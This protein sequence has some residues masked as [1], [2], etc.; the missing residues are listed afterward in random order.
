MK[1]V[2]TTWRKEG[3]RYLF[4]VLSVAFVTA[5]SSPFN[6][7]INS[8]TAALAYLLVVLFVAM[9]WGVWPGRTAAVLAMLCFDYFFLPPL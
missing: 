2:N 8:T 5:V 6:D 4:A 7:Q 3:R 1:D 9:V